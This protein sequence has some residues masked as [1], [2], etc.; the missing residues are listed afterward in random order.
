[1]C[2]DSCVIIVIFLMQYLSK[3]ILLVKHSG[4][5]LLLCYDS[6][7]D[8]KLT[9]S[10]MLQL[11]QIY[12]V[13]VNKRHLRVNEM[14]VQQQLNGIDCGL[15]SIAFAYHIALGDEPS[16]IHFCASEMHQH[17]IKCFEDG[18]LYSFPQVAYSEQSH[19]R[20]KLRIIKMLNIII[21]NIYI[22]STFV[23]VCYQCI[24][25]KNCQ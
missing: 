21:L 16:A 14:P 15:F 12:E 2:V 7:V 3:S 22:D 19:C 17:L 25:R 9:C 1:M 13:A 20:K 24:I 11:K 5:F 18:Q 8:T 6:C 10:L 4:S 23:I